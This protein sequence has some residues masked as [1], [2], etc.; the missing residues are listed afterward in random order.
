MRNHDQ[1]IKDIQR[2]VLPSTTGK[3]A[4]EQRRI[5]HKQNRSRERDSFSAARQIFNADID[6]DIHLDFDE[7]RATRN[8][9]EMVWERR[10]R[11]KVGPLCNW[12][13]RTVAADEKLRA[14]P[15][16]EQIAFIAALMTKDLIGAHAVSHVHWALGRE[17]HPDRFRPWRTS[18]A[19]ERAE[20]R[21][22]V[23]SDLRRILETGRHRKLNAELRRRFA[24]EDDRGRTDPRRVR[25]LL[26]LHDVDAFTDYVGGS[27]SWY[28]VI[29]RVAN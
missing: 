21:D 23:S 26:G 6:A 20:R 15:L 17:F 11:D 8:M 13:I 29:S 18:Y 14:A 7:G 10:S 4:R 16:H 9:N 24:V 19:V 27:D 3:Y 22:R 2:S 28:E 12:A 1:K 5:I 25:L